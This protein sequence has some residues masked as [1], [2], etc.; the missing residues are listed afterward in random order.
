MVVKWLK[1]VTDNS[2]S[3]SVSS[4]VQPPTFF[5]P[6]QIK[7]NLFESR[8]NFF[9]FL[10]REDVSHCYVHALTLC[11]IHSLISTQTFWRVLTASVDSCAEIKSTPSIVWPILAEWRMVPEVNAGSV[12]VSYSIG[13][14]LWLAEVLLLATVLVCPSDW[15]KCA[16]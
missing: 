5:T 6:S 12:H 11:H 1:Y 9:F 8:K 16:C 4:I 15:L 10:P 14:P 7:P 13:L 2:D 3:S